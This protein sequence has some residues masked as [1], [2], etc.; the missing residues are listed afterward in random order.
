MGAQA[1]AL[2]EK[3][4]RRKTASSAHEDRRRVVTRQW[5]TFSERTKQT[6]R[7]PGLHAG[8]QSGPSADDAI[9]YFDG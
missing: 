2:R 7:M 1:G 8:K 5:K 4:E 9:D 6:Q 3:V